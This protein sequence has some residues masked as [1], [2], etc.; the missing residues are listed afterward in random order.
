MHAQAH[1][2]YT[3]STFS[4][5]PA[6]P[7]L[8]C[9]L[10]LGAET[11]GSRKKGTANGRN[12]Q[13]TAS[14]PQA[15]SSTAGSS[16]SLLGSCHHTRC[17][18]SSADPGLA[19][20]RL[21]DLPEQRHRLAN[22][23]AIIEQKLRLCQPVDTSPPSAALNT[24]ASPLSTL[25]LS[26]LLSL[27]SSDLRINA[28]APAEQPLSRSAVIASPLSSHRISAHDYNLAPPRTLTRSS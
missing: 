16:L 5:E 25:S 1:S 13:L 12:K 7:H 3:V 17:G 19:L 6:W 26:D 20:R 21:S 15:N 27:D 14:K 24:H 22:S 18:T 28:Y 9:S 11:N 4:G 23:A 8:N 10:M 2:S